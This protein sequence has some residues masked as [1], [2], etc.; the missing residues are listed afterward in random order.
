MTKTTALFV[1]YWLL[2]SYGELVL[3]LA[4][5]PFH[6]N[7]PLLHPF[8]RGWV[9][10]W[11]HG[12]LLKSLL[13]QTFSRCW[14]STQLFAAILLRIPSDLATNP[15][16]S[17]PQEGGWKHAAEYCVKNE[18]KMWTC[19]PTCQIFLGPAIWINSF[20][21]FSSTIDL[22]LVLVSTGKINKFQNVHW[23]N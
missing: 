5:P 21:N 7:P 19:L 22:V 16:D 2:S 11:Q 9:R 4:T 6:Q 13:F 12:P 10:C 15:K 23:R 1:N 20:A 3:Q 18:S 8:I 17:L 14:S